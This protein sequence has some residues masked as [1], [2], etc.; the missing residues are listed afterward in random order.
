ME[1]RPA[2]YNTLRTCCLLLH[3]SPSH[4]HTTDKQLT[5]QHD[6]QSVTDVSGTNKDNHVVMFNICRINQKAQIMKNES[7]TESHNVLKFVLTQ[8]LLKLPHLLME[9]GLC[10]QT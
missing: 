4:S 8:Q 9:S 10:S 3:V 1:E 6:T 7:E 2:S 5:D